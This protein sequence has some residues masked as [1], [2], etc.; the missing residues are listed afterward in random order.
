MESKKT[1][2]FVAG[3]VFIL[4][5]SA[6]SSASIAATTLSGVAGG[7]PVGAGP[8]V[9]FDNLAPA[10]GVA[11]GG[12]TVSF[13]GVEAGPVALP[14]V[15]NR[16]AAPYITGG[17]GASFGNNQP[18][19]P[20]ITRYLSTGIG[21]VK[22][23]LDQYHNYFGL[24]W[25]SVDDYN[26][27]SFYDGANLLFSY[28]GLD[29][30]RLASGSQSAAGTFYVNIN[31]DAA[32]DRVVASSASYAFE[33]DNV[34]LDVNLAIPVEIPPIP[35]PHTYTLLFAGLLLVGRMAMRRSSIRP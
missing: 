15:V 3:M 11:G 25:G 34:A 22:M 20:N 8:Y 6:I 7:T 4:C 32:F 21:Q 35:E 10:G 31:S 24:L 18:D 28:T 26:T 33:F 13:N 5:V 29:V 1:G 17:N 9:N 14:D 16:Y 2:F 12:I 19:G 27:L 30:D 23:Q